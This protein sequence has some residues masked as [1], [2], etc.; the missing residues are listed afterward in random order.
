MGL[1]APITAAA[2]VSRLGLPAQDCSLRGLFLGCGWA[3]A[4]RLAR[5]KVHGAA[6]AKPQLVGPQ[7]SAGPAGSANDRAVLAGHESRCSC[8]G[9]CARGAQCCLCCYW[10]VAA[11]SQ[12][13][14]LSIFVARRL[15]R[16]AKC[17]FAHW[18]LH[19]AIASGRSP[20][21]Q[22]LHHNH[23]H[24]LRRPPFL[25]P[26]THGGCGSATDRLPSPSRS[27]ALLPPR[28]THA[29]GQ[30]RVCRIGER[31]VPTRTHTVPSFSLPPS[32]LERPPCLP[33]P[34]TP[35]AASLRPF[36][37]VPSAPTIPRH[38]RI[39]GLVAPCPGA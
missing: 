32:S 13:S 21:Q 23:H 33:R 16:S 4:A 24:A 7:R 5:T 22:H 12:R 25:L 36:D 19:H 30:F 34:P 3:L 15:G 39:A 26:Q 31:V 10:S 29:R 27:S 35:P 38:R 9:H 18:Q 1:A 11:A 8:S 20:R 37:P 14:A 28:S 17:W 6:T 2:G